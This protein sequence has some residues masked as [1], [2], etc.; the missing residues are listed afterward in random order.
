M[1]SHRTLFRWSAALRKQLNGLQIGIPKRLAAFTLIEL[2][3]VIAI[4]AILVGMLLPALGKAKESSRGIACLNNLRQIALASA[5][6]ADD[7]DDAY[8]SFR[9]WLYTKVGDVSTGKLFPYLES[10][11]AYLCPTDR[12]ELGFKGRPRQE[13]QTTSGF[14]NRNFKRDYSYGMNCGICHTTK[15]SAFVAPSKTML[16]MEGTLGPNDYSGQ[17]GPALA[18]TSLAFRHNTRGQMAMSDLHVEKMLKRGYDEVANT[19][20]FW[21]PSDVKLTS[22]QDR[23]FMNLK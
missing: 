21:L 17:V 23:F 19:K 10:K 7:H 4:I 12:I 5:V 8:P 15:I 1:N 14:G 9:N 13:G 6:Y 2:L 18:S 11:P 20:R 16:Y 3:V 22:P